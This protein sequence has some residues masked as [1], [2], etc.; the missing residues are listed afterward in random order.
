ML[1]I[2]V[3]PEP[4]IRCL[5]LDIGSKIYA[6]HPVLSRRLEDFLALD[7]NADEGSVLSTC[8]TVTVGRPL[9]CGSSITAL[10]PRCV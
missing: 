7:V 3:A 8:Y 5:Q 6:A 4:M 1:P 2:R 9:F 10:P